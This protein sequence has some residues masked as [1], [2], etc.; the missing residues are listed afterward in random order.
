MS[1]DRREDA[2]YNQDIERQE[3]E[4]H[5]E[6]MNNSAQGIGASLGAHNGPQGNRVHFQDQIAEQIIGNNGEGEIDMSEQQLDQE[7]TDIVHDLRGDEPVSA[8]V[9]IRDHEMGSG[10]EAPS[11][12][13]N[14]NYN[15]N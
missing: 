10:L 5:E 1:R 2:R 6:F 13:F 12:P 8:T 11:N 14:D 7:E 3:N 9:H 4:A 15:P